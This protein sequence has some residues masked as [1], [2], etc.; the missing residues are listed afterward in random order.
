MVCETTRQ[1]TEAG[2]APNAIRAPISRMRC[3]TRYEST[4]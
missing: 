4:P 2:V 3:A 1:A